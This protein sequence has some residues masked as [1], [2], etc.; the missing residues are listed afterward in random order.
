MQGKIDLYVDEICPNVEKIRSNVD[1]NRPKNRGGSRPYY[2]KHRAAA[3]DPRLGVYG[4][5]APDCHRRGGCG[6]HAPPQ[7]VFKWRSFDC[8]DQMANL[9]R[10]LPRGNT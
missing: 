4:G 6:R 5:N 8:L 10:L 2:E 3:R 1:E 9:G 7:K